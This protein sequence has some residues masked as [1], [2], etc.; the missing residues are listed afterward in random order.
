MRDLPFTICGVDD[1]DRLVTPEVSHVVS[2]I[3]PGWPSIG[4]LSRLP[5]SRVH[6]FNFNDVI[7]PRDEHDTLPDASSVARIF[8]TRSL[9][10]MTRAIRD[11][12][13]R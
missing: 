8:S 12:A 10:R 7:A 2:I 11:S 4:A 9:S 3:D 6:R 1:L 13:L 5:A